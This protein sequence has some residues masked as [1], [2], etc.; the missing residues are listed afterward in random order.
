MHIIY[1][2]MFQ[3]VNLT[4]YTCAY[5]PKAG[6]KAFSDLTADEISDL[7]LT[8]QKVGSRLECHHKASSVTFTIQASNRYILTRLDS[9][10]TSC[11]GT[12]LDLN[13][14]D[15]CQYLRMDPRQDRQY[16]MYISISSPRKVGDF[17][18]NDEIYDAVR[19]ISDNSC[20]RI[21][22]L[23]LELNKSFCD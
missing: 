14:F 3:L 5:L 13:C 2:L 1:I 12:S 9:I 19:Y 11:L 23:N 18:K 16:L 15:V 4:L 21:I 10:L 7:W 17:E 8:A 22:P 6:S 20:N